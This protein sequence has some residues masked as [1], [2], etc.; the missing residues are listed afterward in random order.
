MWREIL[1]GHQCKQQKSLMNM[2]GEEEEDKEV[3]HDV[4]NE[5]LPELEE[6]GTLSVHAIEGKCG[7]ETVRVT[8][9]HKNR[10]LLNLI[11]SGSTHNFMDTKVAKELKA[12]VGETP[13]MSITAFDGKKTLRSS[14]TLAFEWRIH[15]Y[16]FRFDLRLLE[17]GRFDMILG[18]DLIKTFNPCLF[19]FENSA[20]SFKY[21]EKEIILQ[22]VK[23]VVPHSKLLQ[24]GRLLDSSILHSITISAES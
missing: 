7:V 23:R 20:A 2:Q 4:T 18:V 10:E 21:Q 14:M 15:Q 11:D 12:L 3:W 5:T 19:D 1:P 6:E 16:A 17:M 22:G 8:G 24:C 13:F 9:K